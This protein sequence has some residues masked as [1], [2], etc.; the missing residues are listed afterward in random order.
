MLG[1]FVNA[2][3]ALGAI[4]T[5]RPAASMDTATTS[6]TIFLL[7]VAP[8]RSDR[9]GALTTAGAGRRARSLS[10]NPRE[11]RDVVK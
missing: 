5:P 11:C 6:F 2:L 1:Q 3:A 4:P 7:T 9:L 8:F 10:G